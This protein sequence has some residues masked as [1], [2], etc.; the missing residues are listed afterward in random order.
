MPQHQH[1]KVQWTCLP[2]HCGS[3]QSVMRPV[4]NHLTLQLAQRV[5]IME[6]HLLG[7]ITDTEHSRIEVN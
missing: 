7:I 5:V 1:Q 6:A 2:F 3:C 4:I